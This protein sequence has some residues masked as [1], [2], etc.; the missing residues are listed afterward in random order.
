MHEALTPD[1][2]RQ[3]LPHAEA[4]AVTVQVMTVS[5]LV[6]LVVVVVLHGLAAAAAAAVTAYQRGLES[7]RKVAEEEPLLTQAVRE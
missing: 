7:V 6:V 3:L 5:V 2:V 1:D 4:Q